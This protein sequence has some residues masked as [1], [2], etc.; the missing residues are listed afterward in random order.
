[1][2]TFKNNLWNG[3]VQAM[4]DCIAVY[5]VSYKNPNGRDIYREFIS[6]Q[7]D[8]YNECRHIAFNIGGQRLL[9]VIDLEALHREFLNF[10]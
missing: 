4:E 5:T 9:E 1:M 3:L 7:E 10:V 2:D 6:N 8:F